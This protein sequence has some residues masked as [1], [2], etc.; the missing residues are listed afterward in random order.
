[1]ADPSSTVSGALIGEIFVE[2]GHITP[3]QL[4]EALAVQAETGELLGEVL[5]SRFNVPRVELAGVLAEQWATMERG[6]GVAPNES[7]AEA[8]A[9]LPVGPWSSGVREEVE[10]ERRPIGEIFVEQG[11]VTP[12]QLES[13][14]AIQADSG[15]RLGEVLVAQGV[16]TRLEL[17]GALADQWSTL[18]KIRPPEP[19]PVEPWQE[20]AVRSAAQADEQPL[21]PTPHRYESSAEIEGL[22]DAVRALEERLRLVAATGGT[23]TTSTPD[24]ALRELDATFGRKLEELAQQFDEALTADIALVRD[25]VEELKSSGGGNGL[26]A[27]SDERI[28]TLERR[29]ESAVDALGSRIEAVGANGA[30]TAA[31]DDL[32]AAVASLEHRTTST[33]TRDD[34]DALRVAFAAVSDD[35]RRLGEVPSGVTHDELQHHLERIASELGKRI[36]S[37]GAATAATEGLDQV[38]AQL[39]A[40][41]EH[42]AAI[43][44]AGFAEVEAVATRLDELAGAI[45][46]AQQST[47]ELRERLDDETASRATLSERLDQLSGRL[48]L[49]DGL[50]SR[51]EGAET[52]VRA[53]LDAVHARL[54]AFSETPARL[55]ATIGELDSRLSQLAGTVASLATDERLSAVEGA[56]AELTELRSAVAALAEREPGSSAPADAVAAVTARLDELAGRVDALVSADRFVELERAFEALRSTDSGQF[57]ALRASLKELAGDLRELSLRPAGVPAEELEHQLALVRGRIEDVAALHSSPLRGPDDVTRAQLDDAIAAEREAR[58]ELARRLAELGTPATA[59]AV[60]ELRERLEA[61]G[62]AHGMDGLARDA[63]R[64]LDGRL[65]E[66]AARASDTHALDELRAQLEELASGGADHEA[67]ARLDA[68]GGALDELAGRL[69]EAA[70]G[71]EGLIELRARLEELAAGYGGRLEQLEALRHELDHLPN[72]DSGP[73]LAELRASIE[74]SG[75]VDREH[76]AMLD[77]LRSRLDELAAS[78]TADEASR[79]ALDELRAR[80]EHLAGASVSDETARAELA[81]LRDR[82]DQTNVDT[83]FAEVWGRVAQ[84]DELRARVDSLGAAA[85]AYAERAQLDELSSRLAAFVERPEL[86]DLGHRLATLAERLDSVAQVDWVAGIERTATEATA[87]LHSRLDALEDVATGSTGVGSQELAD[88]RAALTELDGRLQALASTLDETKIGL[89]SIDGNVAATLEAALKNMVSTGT[90]AELAEQVHV[91]V[92]SLETAGDSTRAALDELGM[93][94]G[95][96]E[97]HAWALPEE[98]DERFSRLHQELSARIEA[99]GNNHGQALA[100]V[101]ARLDESVGVDQSRLTALEASTAH[102]TSRLE[103]LEAR[104]SESNGSV[105]ERVDALEVRVEVEAR[106]AEE[107]G[108]AIEK[109]IRKGLAGLAERFAANEQSYLESGQAL[110]RAIERLGAA[111]IEADT[112]IAGMPLDAPENGYVAFVPTSDGYRLRALDGAIPAVGEL[113][114]LGE[115]GGALRVSRIAT[116]PLPLDRRACAY[117]E[118]V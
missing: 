75:A 48:K 5:V 49:V 24:E 76:S 90:V 37:L 69:S 8:A 22:R 18:Q 99:L 71:A 19:K 73:E 80:V 98:L 103:G 3:A 65:N 66:L 14:L 74:A 82:L 116:S 29:L 84:L 101:H 32:R 50:Q 57:D 39:A 17:A 97:Q 114:D 53:D 35:V 20:L 79:H 16:I 51:V 115:D 96:T 21:S 46:F 33:P 92:A 118:R 1:M 25:A 9:N 6:G 88:A 68:L 102:S 28:A 36:D 45:N 52:A 106:R 78:R 11:V 61:I 117:L 62:S 26:A 110:R 95:A 109:A 44:A 86:D 23:A 113:V 94:L 12:A 7:I 40:L 42:V 93:R 107:Q 100:A 67:R 72:P 89:A 13:A 27:M 4:E 31:I 85:G 47:G 54:E 56:V 2:R 58:A 81:E 30:A 38:R 63:V 105:S 59:A 10:F 15:Q 55:D 60:E 34:L 43:P 77:L 111:V 41:G 112:R 83:R 104:L 108:K 91:R 64:E 87:A 70:A